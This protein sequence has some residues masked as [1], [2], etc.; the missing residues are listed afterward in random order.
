MSKSGPGEITLAESYSAV[1]GDYAVEFEGEVDRKPFDRELLRRFVEDVG[2][3]ARVL[4]LGCGPGH[5]GAYLSDLGCDVIGVDLSPGMIATARELYPGRCFAVGD[6]LALDGADAAFA[7]VVA[8]YSLIHLERDSV[9]TAA[10]EIARVLAPGGRALVSVHEGEGG[11]GRDEWYGK[12]VRVRATLFAPEE[13]GELIS[14]GG[15]D[16]DTID[17]RDPYEL[18]YPTKRIYLRAR[19]PAG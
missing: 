13:I 9:A 19:K 10:R 6:M 4:D 8:F 7:G 12:S 15:L 18:E 17:V 1:A 14:R 16:V 5:I 3:G 2:R 11:V